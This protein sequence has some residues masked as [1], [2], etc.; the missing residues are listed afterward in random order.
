MLL[1]RVAISMSTRDD[2]ECLSEMAGTWNGFFNAPFRHTNPTSRTTLW[3]RPMDFVDATV[4]LE[5]RES[6]ST[7]ACPYTE[8]RNVGRRRDFVACSKL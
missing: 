1:F 5:K 6:I 7:E 3:D 8:L 2:N 4:P